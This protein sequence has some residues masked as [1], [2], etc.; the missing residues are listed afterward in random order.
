MAEHQDARGHRM[1]PGRVTNISMGAGIDNVVEFE[2]AG[3]E[4]RRRARPAGHRC[5]AAYLGL[6][7]RRE[8]STMPRF[9]A[10]LSMLFT[11]AFLDRFERAAQ[12]GF[13][14]VGSSSPAPHGRGDQE[15]AWTPPACRSCCQPARGRL[16]CWR[17]GIACD[18]QRVDEFR[19]AWPRP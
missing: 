18:P 4:R 1:H 11:G 3:P 5:S 19:A 7:L 15:G 10:N 13:E 16:G 9:A 6:T 12:A 8:I 17:R 14:A 2:K